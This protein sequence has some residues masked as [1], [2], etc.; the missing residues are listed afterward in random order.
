MNGL[1]GKRG[2]CWLWPICVCMCAQAFRIG[3]L[4]TLRPRV[5]PQMEARPRLLGFLLCRLRH[6]LVLPRYVEW[7]G[8]CLRVRAVL[9]APLAIDGAG[10]LLLERPIVPASQMLTASLDCGSVLLPETPPDPAGFGVKPTSSACDVPKHDGRA[11]AA[12][13]QCVELS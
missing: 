7:A 5:C 10:Q 12:Y 3:E 1:P 11:H 8:I 4:D 2:V 6:V 9:W 13:A